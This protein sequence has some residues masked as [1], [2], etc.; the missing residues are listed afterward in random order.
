MAREVEID[1]Q[2]V[3]PEI[4]R[5]A[6]EREVTAAPDKEATDVPDPP[7]LLSEWTQQS[8]RRENQSRFERSFF[9]FQVK[10][11]LDTQG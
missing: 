6:Q 3:D 9:P 7:L 5:D 11:N 10:L 1:A 2:E 4:A 8:G